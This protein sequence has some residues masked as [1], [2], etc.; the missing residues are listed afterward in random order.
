[1]EVARAQAD[2]R[3]S[4]VGGGPGMFVSGLVW[5]A[6]ALVLGVAGDKTAF[7]VLFLGGMLIY[8]LGTLI[9]RAVFRRAPA[10]RANP[11]TPIAIESTIAMIGG[12][13]AAWLLLQYAPD[14]AFPV[15]AIAVGTHYF[16]FATLYGDRTYWLVAALITL[17][18]AAAIYLDLPTAQLLLAVAAIEVVFAPIIGLRSK[19]GSAA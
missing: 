11:L 6:A 1:M 17:A 3:T 15:A 9:S 5:G 4:Y 13:F 14:F 19:R 18:G 2:I 10:A 7:A 12:L 8:P 16:A